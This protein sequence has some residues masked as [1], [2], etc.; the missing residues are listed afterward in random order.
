MESLNLMRAILVGGAV[1]AAIVSAAL[2]SWAAA[3]VLCVGIAAH[4][5]MWVYIHRRGTHPTVR[6]DRAEP[7]D[8]GARPV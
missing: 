5:A 1:I 2:G 7:G 4:A 8:A 6:R 3:L